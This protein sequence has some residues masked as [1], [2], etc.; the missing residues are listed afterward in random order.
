MINKLRYLRLLSC[1][2]QKMK[3]LT[4]QKKMKNLF[5]QESC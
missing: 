2:R 5:L 1:D 4:K 3:N